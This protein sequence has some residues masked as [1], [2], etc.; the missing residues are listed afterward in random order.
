MHVS[1]AILLVILAVLA[2]GCGSSGA[3]ATAPGLPTIAPGGAGG[4]TQAPVVTPAGGGGGGGGTVTS[5]TVA[6]GTYTKGKA[7]VEL[8]GDKT[9]TLDMNG[10][11]FAAGGSGAFSYADT[12]AQLSVSI[13][14][15]PQDTGLAIAGKDIITGG[16]WG[17]EC[18]L[19]VTRNDSGGVAGEF[20]CPNVE[21]ADPSILKQLKVSIKGS[22]SAER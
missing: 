2:V 16:T 6:D 17:K 1:R 8:T 20:S 15:G 11:G 3:V 13:V 10:T 21:A 22:F 9:A 14:L 4:A 7:H 18:E 12:T 19:K 5:V